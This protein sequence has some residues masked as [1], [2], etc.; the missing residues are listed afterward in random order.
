MKKVFQLRDQ[1]IEELVLKNFLG[2]KI[3]QVDHIGVLFLTK[4]YAVVGRNPQT[5]ENIT[6]PSR[7][8]PVF[9][10]FQQSNAIPLH[11]S[12]HMVPTEEVF[13]N[14]VLREKFD[15][16]FYHNEELSNVY[17]S[18]LPSKHI[19]MK[20][21]PEE[22]PELRIVDKDEKLLLF[23]SFQLLSEKTQREGGLIMSVGI[24][25][26]YSFPKDVRDFVQSLTPY[27]RVISQVNEAF[28]Y[29]DDGDRRIPNRIDFLDLKKIEE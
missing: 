2:K 14:I 5:L 12:M 23:L 16:F 27:I 8:V 17:M 7:M 18:L 19:N 13:Q 1:T 26:Y 21:N 3:V 10:P 28:G 11:D 4:R 9:L 20:T 25:I 15:I 6:M 29:D 22:K 24:Y